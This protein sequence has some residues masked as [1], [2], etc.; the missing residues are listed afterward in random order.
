MFADTAMAKL[1]NR[2]PYYLEYSFAEPPYFVFAGEVRESW[3]F[4]SP[5][6]HFRHGQTANVGWA[7]GHVDRQ[8]MISYDKNNV[9]GV[10]SSRMSLG[11]FGV[12]ENTYF[13]LK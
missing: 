4:S 5:S 7:D 1:D 11:W 2:T 13:D 6:I 12:L 10:N 9:Y 3:G 8:A